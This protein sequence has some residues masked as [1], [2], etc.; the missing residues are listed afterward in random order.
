MVMAG[1]QAINEHM[2]NCLILKLESIKWQ[3]PSNG[4][5]FLKWLIFYSEISWI[6]FGK[7]FLSVG[8]VWSFLMSQI[9]IQDLFWIIKDVFKLICT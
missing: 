1:R 8:D 2:I 7:I 9:L 6:E 3:T 4:F 5:N